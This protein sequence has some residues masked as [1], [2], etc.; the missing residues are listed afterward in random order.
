MVSELNPIKAQ[1]NDQTEKHVPLRQSQA[2]TSY[3]H[4]GNLIPENRQK[5]N[6]KTIEDYLYHN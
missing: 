5:H 1:K 3:V 6:K 2:H 4:Y